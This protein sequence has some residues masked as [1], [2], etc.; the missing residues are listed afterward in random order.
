MCF[1]P[2]DRSKIITKSW[3]TVQGK[4]EANALFEMKN[5][6]FQKNYNIPLVADIHFAPIAL[7][8]A[9]SDRRA[10]FEQ[11]EYAEDDYQQEREHIEQVS[12]AHSLWIQKHQYPNSSIFYRWDEMRR[13]KE[14]I[15]VAWGA[16]D[17]LRCIRC[18]ML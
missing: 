17:E 1:N 10:Q 18:M 9:E 14:E 6:L 13:N 16:R 11:L 3:I 4:K 8:V 5:T 7:R 2:T 15:T 12:L